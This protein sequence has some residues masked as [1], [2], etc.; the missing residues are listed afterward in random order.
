MWPYDYFNQFSSI[1]CDMSMGKR[2][3]IFLAIWYD[4]DKRGSPQ[5]KKIEKIRGIINN[6]RFDGCRF[7]LVTEKE[8]KKGRFHENI[9]RNIIDATFVICD[10]TLMGEVKL[11]SSFK[12]KKRWAVNPNVMYELGV[13]S[14]W[15]LKEQ[16]IVLYDHTASK[17]HGAELSTVVS[18]IGDLK[19]ELIKDSVS[20]A[21]LTK[22]IRESW[23]DYKGKRDLLINNVRS[24]LDNESLR[25]LL[26]PYNTHGLLFSLNK[27]ICGQE[28]A[29]VRWLLNIGI[30]RTITFPNDEKAP[31]AYS[32]TRVGQWIVKEHDSYIYPNI[33]IDT[34]ELIHFLGEKYRKY[35]KEKLKWFK[36]FYNV[37]SW[38]KFVSIIT[39]EIPGSLRTAYTRQGNNVR[40]DTNLLYVFLSKENYDTVKSVIIEKMKIKREPW[41]CFFKE[42][43]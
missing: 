32:L 7:E 22:I 5:T 19:R 29:T 14:A 4:G 8:I 39:N 20:E 33:L 30:L 43:E 3:K 11:S 10:I 37:K 24:K 40:K 18:N 23:D 42:E 36:V 27:P 12:D 13:A 26:E 2:K 9:L 6:L 28:I 17:K 16:V 15:K 41:A 35:F 21:K 31:Y 1:E 38:G 34:Y 25:F